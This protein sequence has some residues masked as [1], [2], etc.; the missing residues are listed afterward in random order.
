MISLDEQSV[1]WAVG[2]LALV[3]CA[4]AVIRSCSKQDDDAFVEGQGS[5]FRAPSPLSSSSSRV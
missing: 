4:E 5:E 1:W 3:V 2:A